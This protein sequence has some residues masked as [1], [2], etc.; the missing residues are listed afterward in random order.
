MRYFF[1]YWNLNYDTYASRVLNYDTQLKYYNNLYSYLVNINA[2]L[3]KIPR[4]IYTPVPPV[5]Y[6]KLEAVSNTKTYK[7]NASQRS[8]KSNHLKDNSFNIINIPDRK[9][10]SNVPSNKFINKYA[11]HKN[12]QIKL[13]LI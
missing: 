4:N 2:D 12:L 13:G 8:I 3:Q 6:Q 7:K 1:K 9:N 11:L 5:I 10:Y